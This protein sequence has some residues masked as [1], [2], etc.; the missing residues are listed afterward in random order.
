MATLAEHRGPWRFDELAD[1]PDDDHRYEVVD[2]RLV[3]TPPGH[4]H[5]AIGAELLFQLRARCPPA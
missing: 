2:G 3:V 1:L 5:Q 4:R